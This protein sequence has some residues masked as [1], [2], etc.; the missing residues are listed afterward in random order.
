MKTRVLIT[1]ASS[2]IGRA[3]A[4]RLAARGAEVWLLGRDMD[5]LEAV[6]VETGGTPLVCD[7]TNDVDVRLAVA[8]FATDEESLPVLINSAGVAAFGAFDESGGFMS[9]VMTNL[10][11]P[12][13]VTHAILPHMLSQGRGRIVNVASVAA[14][15]V[16]KMAAGYC[17]SKAGLVMFGRAI[18]AEYRD[19]GILV[20][21][22]L[23]GAVDTPIWDKAEFSPP[24]EQMLPA[25]AVAE[26]IEMVVFARADRAFDEIAMMP[27]LGVL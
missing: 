9:E 20:T 2:G 26:A 25:D 11:G 1:G 27:P 13:V 22:I 7:V 6:A 12:M 10:M 19:R 15:T 21:N 3:T 8:S 17:A 16:F 14:T 24:R 23:P 4:I 18:A 5:R